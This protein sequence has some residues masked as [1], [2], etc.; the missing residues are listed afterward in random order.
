MFHTTKKGDGGVSSVEFLFCRILKRQRPEP[1]RQH[2]FHHQKLPL[3]QSLTQPLRA[4][5]PLP[6][7]DQPITTS[8]AAPG[9][10]AT[11]AASACSSRAFN[12]R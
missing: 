5:L 6:T 1:A 8:F 9:R 11:S 2:L 10:R 12:G 3:P 4:S 7:G